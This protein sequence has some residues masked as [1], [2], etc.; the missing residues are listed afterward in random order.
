MN[1][2]KS[3]KIFGAVLIILGVGIAVVALLHTRAARMPAAPS[4]YEPFA[5][6]LKEQGA[7]FYGAFWCPHCQ[8][9]EKEFKMSRQELEKIGLYVECSMPDGQTQTQACIEKGIQSYPTW[10]FA[11]GSRLSG[12]IPLDQL[13][14]KTACE[15]P[16]D[17]G[18]N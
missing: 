12:E 17:S 8:A 5:S 1:D 16:A 13:A 6:C 10:I 18:T 11:D 7:T 9:Q 4:V 2:T 3:I 15:L 14:A